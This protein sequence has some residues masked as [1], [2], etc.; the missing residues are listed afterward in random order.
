MRV[1]LDQGHAPAM[2]L[3]ILAMVL[4]IVC[5]DQLLWR[6]LVVWVEKF[7]LD[8]SGDGAPVPSSWVL[9]FLR[10]GRGSGRAGRVERRAS[11][12]APPAAR[13]LARPGPGGPALP[14]RGSP[15][16]R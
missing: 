4:M 5:L 2:A 3:A 6:P 15:V 13:P 12:P 14:P 16:S 10:R 9:E 8:E 11:P 7:R 1:G